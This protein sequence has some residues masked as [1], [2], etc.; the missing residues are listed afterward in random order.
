VFVLNRQYLWTGTF[1]FADANQRQ[2]TIYLPKLKPF[3]ESVSIEL[4]GYYNM[5][6]ITA[7]TKIQIE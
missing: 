1:N 6:P 4:T 5:A 7:G 3:H 2:I